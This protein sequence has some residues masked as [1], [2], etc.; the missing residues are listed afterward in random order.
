MTELLILQI[1]IIMDS[2]RICL[3]ISILPLKSAELWVYLQSNLARF[4]MVFNEK[5][6]D[7]LV[8]LRTNM[9]KSNVIKS[10]SS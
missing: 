1:I 5:S 8:F 9:A 3:S 7:L 2:R 6:N 4:I 10:N